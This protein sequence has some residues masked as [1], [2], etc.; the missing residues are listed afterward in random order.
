MATPVVPAGTPDTPGADGADGPEATA[1]SSSQVNLAWT[2]ATDNVGVT[3]YLV[4]RCQGA[5]CAIVRPDRHADNAVA[6]SDPGLTASTSYSYRVRAT[7]GAGNLGGYS[8]V[9][10]ATTQSGGAS[11]PGLVAAYTFDEGAGTTVADASGMGNTGTIGTATWSTPGKYGNSLSFNGTSAR[12]TIPD[13]P[14]LRLT[15]AMTL[16]AW[17]LRAPSPTR[18][19]MWSTR[20]TTTTT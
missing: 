17:V 6:F 20:A 4:E 8:N 19:A 3:D 14:S 18:G 10:T 1:V 11:P 12:V 5:G 15:I 7:D 9:A 16:E 2:A 13:A